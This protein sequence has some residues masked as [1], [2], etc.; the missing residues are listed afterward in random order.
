MKRTLRILAAVAA[1][2]V[3]VFVVVLLTIDVNQYKD[4]IVKV[5][6]TNTGRDF[7]IDGDI[8]LGVSLFPTVVIEKAS[9]G[10]AP[11]GTRETMLEIER[12]EVSIAILPLLGG[13]VEINTFQL[14]RPDVYLETDKQGRGNWMLQTGGKKEAAEKETAP[15]EFRHAKLAFNQILIEQATISYRD[16]S[17]DEKLVLS[18]EEAELSAGGWGDA[19]RL[20]IEAQYGDRA[21]RVSG[22]SGS[23]DSLLA[24][25]S[26]PLDLSVEL[27]GLR[28]AINGSLARPLEGGGPDL[29]LNLTA[30]SL[31]DLR[32]AEVGDLPAVSPVSLQA[33]LGGEQGKYRV[34]SLQAQIGDSDLGGEIEIDTGASVP[35]VTAR[36]TSRLIDLTPFE[37]EEKEEEKEQPPER[38]FSP[39]PLP[40]D[41]L[42]SVNVD[43]SLAVESVRSKRLPMSKAALKLKLQ[44]GA[45][46]IKPITAAIAGGKLSAATSLA[47]AGK[48]RM[49][50]DFELAIDGLMPGRLPKF[51][52]DEPIR[53]AKTDITARAS[54][55]GDSVRAIMAGLNGGLLV[56]TGEGVIKSSKLEMA[57]ADVFARTFSMLK[58]DSGEDDVTELQCAV[59][60]FTIEDGLAVS[61][62]GIA[63]ETPRITVVGGGAINLKTE[64]IDLGIRPHAREGLGIGAGQLAELVRLRGTLAR[65]EAK[66]STLAA[67][68]TAATVGAAFATGG[69]SLLAGGLFDRATADP[70]P[71][72]TALGEKPEGESADAGQP[73]DDAEEKQSVG[74][75]VKGMFKGMFGD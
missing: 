63:M 23:L 18:V 33:S 51:K 41:Q 60:R 71:C 9:L 12:L 25:T 35:A 74:D 59:V 36:L 26:F 7:S 15:R 4:D 67:V 29:K 55:R 66:P 20:E 52:Q 49:K 65:P 31:R 50:L 45:L 62:N 10:N 44:N 42:K 38:L 64:E 43:L 73:A 5:V 24:N 6:E 68:K 75:K 46:A 47:P 56:K 22:T 19:M 21:I 69:L 58:P 13:D 61:D 34:K 3:I 1:V 27:G 14:V 30:D 17:T 48:K 53:D 28:V 2:I 70:H 39:D 32:V 8:H 72:A 37:P 54:G 11:W 16:G 40:V 57:G